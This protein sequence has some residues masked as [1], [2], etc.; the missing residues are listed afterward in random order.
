M[1][2]RGVFEE[3]MARLFARV[4][5]VN[6]P[7]SWLMSLGFFISC[8]MDGEMAARLRWVMVVATRGDTT[9]RRVKCEIGTM[10]GN[11]QPADA[12]RGGVAMRSDA[13]TSRD[14]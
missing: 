2:S 13:T 7:R 9:T 4:R 10:R 1:T 5:R 3:E 12:L 8:D 11:L 6:G 14:K